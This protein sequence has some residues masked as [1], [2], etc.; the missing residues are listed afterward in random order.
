MTGGRQRDDGGDVGKKKRWIITFI[1]TSTVN[2]TPHRSLTRQEGSVI[3]TVITPEPT[4]PL[5]PLLA[6]CAIGRCHNTI[7]LTIKATN[8]IVSEPPPSCITKA[9]PSPLPSLSL[10]TSSSPSP[11]Y[12]SSPSSLPPTPLLSNIPTIINNTTSSITITTTTGWHEEQRRSGYLFKS[13]LHYQLAA[14]RQ[15]RP[16]LRQQCRPPPRTDTRTRSGAAPSS[17]PRPFPSAK[18]RDG[19]MER[20]KDGKMEG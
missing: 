16:P 17:A 7:T 11:R 13:P 18:W 9:T 2:Y 15:V 10:L 4:T 19:K 8:T 1:T 20:W 3:T 6:T 5:C 14:D 12:S